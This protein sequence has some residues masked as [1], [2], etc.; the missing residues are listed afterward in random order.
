MGFLVALSTGPSIIFGAIP[1]IMHAASRASLIG[2]GGVLNDFIMTKSFT[3]KVLKA[4]S[5]ASNN[6]Y[7]SLSLS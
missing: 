4:L 6:G 1:N 5:A 2:A 7:A 3:F